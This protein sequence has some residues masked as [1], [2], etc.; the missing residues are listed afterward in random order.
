MHQSC[1]N[2]LP[3]VLIDYGEC[4]LGLPRLSDN[5][6][7][8]PNYYRFAILFYHGYQGYMIDKVDVHEECDFL[9]CKAAFCSKETPEE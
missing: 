6:T 7:R 3:L 4:H 5:V 1:A 9:L 2:T 8:A